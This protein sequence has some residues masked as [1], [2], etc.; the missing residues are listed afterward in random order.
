MRQAFEFAGVAVVG[1][2]LAL[3]AAADVRRV[4]EPAL[5]R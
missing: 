4:I 5:P 3:S 2:A 1:T